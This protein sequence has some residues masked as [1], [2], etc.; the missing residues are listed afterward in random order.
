VEDLDPIDY[1]TLLHK[2]IPNALREIFEECGMELLALY[3]L[4]DDVN[5]PEYVA[6]VRLENET[7]AT[8]LT[9]ELDVDIDMEAG[10]VTLLAMRLTRG[11]ADGLLPYYHPV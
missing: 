6:K 1:D 4:K 5:L 9:I 8:E 2:D 11:A 3:H 7:H 10:E